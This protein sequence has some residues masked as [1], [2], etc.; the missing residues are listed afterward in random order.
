[1]EIWKCNNHAAQPIRNRAQPIRPTPNTRHRAF[2]QIAAGVRCFWSSWS[3]RGSAR[4][5]RAPGLSIL[6]W[7]PAAPAL[8]DVRSKSSKPGPCPLGWRAVRARAAVPPPSIPRL[9]RFPPRPRP[10]A[11]DPEA[12]HLRRSTGP[13]PDAPCGGVGITTWKARA[14]K[15]CSAN[16][17]R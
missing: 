13:V 12:R 3:P 7:V 14:P 16:S 1:M 6:H 15:A 5:L 4:P 9:N 10:R 2:R 17:V 11:E 8:P